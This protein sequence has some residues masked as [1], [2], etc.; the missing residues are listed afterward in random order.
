MPA[1]GMTR[2]QSSSDRASDIVMERPPQKGGLF[3]QKK[4]GDAGGFVAA[5][6]RAFAAPQRALASGRRCANSAHDFYFYQ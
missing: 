3:P 5:S 1:K 6:G 4:G 2:R